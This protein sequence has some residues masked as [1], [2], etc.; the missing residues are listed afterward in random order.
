MDEF[1][2]DAAVH[3][4]TDEYGAQLQFLRNGPVPPLRGID[5]LVQVQV[6]DDELSQGILR[7]RLA[8]A[9]GATVLAAAFGPSLIPLPSCGVDRDDQGDQRDESAKDGIGGSGP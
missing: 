6:R 2:E 8:L 3:P 4:L 9:G 1:V 7:P 5:E